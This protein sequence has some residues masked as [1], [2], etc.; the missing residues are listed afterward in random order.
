MLSKDCY[1]PDLD[2]DRLS[3]YPL[4]KTIFWLFLYVIMVFFIFIGFCIARLSEIFINFMYTWLRPKTNLQ[5]G[6]GV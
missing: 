2:L 1:S 3:E 6:F 5:N 4:S